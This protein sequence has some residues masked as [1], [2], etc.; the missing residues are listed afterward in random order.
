MDKEFEEVLEVLTS[1]YDKMITE[2]MRIVQQKIA[3]DILVAAIPCLANQVSDTLAPESFA[4]ELAKAVIA[5]DRERMRT[6]DRERM[7]LANEEQA[8][9]ESS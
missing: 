9:S 4:Q 6:F 2:A 1:I 7:R 3:G 5:F 8:S